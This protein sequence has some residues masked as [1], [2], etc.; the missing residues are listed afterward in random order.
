MARL[1]HPQAAGQHSHGFEMDLLMK[2][3][4]E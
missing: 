4:D 3:E 1:L 2:S